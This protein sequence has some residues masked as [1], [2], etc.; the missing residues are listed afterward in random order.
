MHT[1]HSLVFALL[2]MFA[3]GGALSCTAQQKT[4]LSMLPSDIRQPVKDALDAVRLETK[5]RD[6]VI[7][8]IASN[9]AGFVTLYKELRIAMNADPA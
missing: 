8:A 2:V 6:R 5:D 3:A 1:S 4:P 9:P 7:T